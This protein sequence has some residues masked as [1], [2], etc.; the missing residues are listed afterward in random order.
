MIRYS[1]LP[2]VPAAFNAADYYAQTYRHGDAPADGG[3]DAGPDAGPRDDLLLQ[4]QMQ[5]LQA[6]AGQ[7]DPDNGPNIQGAPAT[8]DNRGQPVFNGA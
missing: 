1:V 4:A 7:D 3:P 8:T 5:A 6:V 2:Q